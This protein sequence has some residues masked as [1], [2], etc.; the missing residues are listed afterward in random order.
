MDKIIPD[1]I[2][3]ETFD[4]NTIITFKGN[5]LGFMIHAN[6]QSEDD[7]V[8]EAVIEHREDT[9]VM[10]YTE[11]NHKWKYYFSPYVSQ[12]Y[13][14]FIMAEYAKTKPSVDF[15]YEVITLINKIRQRNLSCKEVPGQ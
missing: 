13:I 6:F 4:A 1:D 15:K 2:I 12:R 7:I 3:D 14:K 11:D 9:S 8:Y 5:K 10:Y